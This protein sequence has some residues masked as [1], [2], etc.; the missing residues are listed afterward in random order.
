MEA[1]TQ[2]RFK[3]RYGSLR[4]LKARVFVP[5]YSVFKRI[6]ATDVRDYCL[7]RYSTQDFHFIR[8]APIGRHAYDLTEK[9]ANQIYN[10]LVKCYSLEEI[11]LTIEVSCSGEALVGEW[12]LTVRALKAL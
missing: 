5:Y 6:L 7:A 11:I 9:H 8:Y 12:S 2:N 3:Q 4:T 1:S 10:K